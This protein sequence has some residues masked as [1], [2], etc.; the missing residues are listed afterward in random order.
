MV[1]IPTMV[2]T[3]GWFMIVIPTLYGKTK[4]VPVTTNQ[5]M[6]RLTTQNWIH[7][8]AETSADGLESLFVAPLGI[9]FGNM[10]VS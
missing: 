4:H 5:W 7:P 1:N 3:G 9:F 6:H 8:S 2:M 10:G